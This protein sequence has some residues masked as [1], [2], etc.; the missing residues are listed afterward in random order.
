[1]QFKYLH[2]P[3]SGLIH[4]LAVILSLIGTY[5][6]IYNSLY[7]VLRFWHVVSFTVFGLGLILLYTASTLYHWL[8][9]S[10]AAKRMLRKFD[11][12][13]IFILIAAT[14]TPVC[15]IP[16]R[17]PWGWFI[18]VSIWLLALFGIAVDYFYVSA[19]RK[20]TAAIYIVMGWFVIIAIW[21]VLNILKLNGFLW[22]LAGGLFYTFG[23]MIYARK[24]PDPWPEVFGF[25]EI[26]HIFVVL[27]S[28]FHFGLMYYHVLP[29]D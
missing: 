14:Y 3:V 20:F 5:I 7:P 23:G 21:P 16:L 4:F 10:K 24:K 15:V 1:M 25:H 18:G 9:V 17:G 11:H 27:G 6:L 22:L 28:L 29:C 2:D 13:M 8:P 19:P 12:F 26:F